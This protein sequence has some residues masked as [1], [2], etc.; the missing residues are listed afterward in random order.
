LSSP[1]AGRQ[2]GLL[3]LC[4]AL[5][6]VDNVTLIALPALVVATAAALYAWRARPAAGSLRA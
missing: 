6:Y 4:Q 1:S 2:I 3:A 5:L